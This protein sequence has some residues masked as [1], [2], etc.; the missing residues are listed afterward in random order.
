MLL[1]EGRLRLPWTG[2][3]FGLR[4]DF[5]RKSAE[6]YFIRVAMLVVAFVTSIL[7]A[8]L[9]GP[10]GRGQ[11]AVTLAI[12]YLGVQVCNLGLYTTNVYLVAG[13]RQRLG[14]LWGNSVAISVAM[15]VLAA[16][17]LAGLNTLVPALRLLPGSLLWLAV[18]WVPVGLIF[19]LGQSLLLGIQEIRAYNAGEALSK[20]VL[21]AIVAGLFVAKQP[22]PVWSVLAN[23]LGL[24]M[25][26]WLTARIIAHQPHGKLSTSPRIFTENFGYGA[27]AYFAALF[28]FLVLRAD[29]LIVKKMLGDRDA[30]F[31]GIAVNLADSVAILPTIVA[32]ILFARLSAVTDVNE[33]LRLLRLAAAGTAI[34]LLPMLAVGGLLAGKAVPFL[35]GPSFQPAVPAL[36]WLLPGMF[37]LGMHAIYVQF[38]NSAGIP[39]QVLWTWGACAVAN[40]ASNLWAVPRYGIR[41]ASVV[42]SICYTIAFLVIVLL[43]SKHRDTAAVQS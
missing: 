40:I 3:E 34:V 42:S 11:Y 12:G 21:L 36:L 4:T 18:L 15:G 37:S 26:I 39:S 25:G 2:I 33:R 35:F 1:R 22:A 29:L 6:T 27:K 14:A 7:L 17:V 43:V 5:F 38:L 32:S 23:L 30:G 10:E 19:L 41:G 13:E 28:S 9:L 8:R 31:Y 24:G 16:V 20:V